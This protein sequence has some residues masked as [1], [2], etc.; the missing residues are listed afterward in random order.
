[1]SDAAQA[2]GRLSF[3]RAALV[4]ARRDFLA[5]LFGRTFF[6]FLLGPLFPAIVATM[7]G[8]IGAQTQ[9]IAMSADIGLAMEAQ[10]TE[11][12]LRARDELAA[13]IEEQYPEGP[14]DV[15]PYGFW[16]G[17]FPL[18]D[19]CDSGSGQVVITSNGTIG[20][21]SGKTAAVKGPSVF[22]YVDYVDH[23]YLT[24]NNCTIIDEIDGNVGDDQV[25]LNGS[26]TL[27][28]DVTDAGGESEVWT[29]SLKGLIQVNPGESAPMV[30]G[31]DPD[32]IWGYSEP[33]SFDATATFETSADGGICY[34]GITPTSDGCDGIFFSPNGE[35]VHDLLFYYWD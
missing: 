11:A 12:M 28:D 15:V 22:E 5:I 18:T 9:S 19:V 3:W 4:V 13:Q 30:T 31:T 27:T 8:G 20:P 17:S 2:P 29:V 25:T 24:F 14:D 1:M 10:D 16:V 33:V 6:L 35:T 26:L 32:I 7:A 21:F 23:Y 34:G